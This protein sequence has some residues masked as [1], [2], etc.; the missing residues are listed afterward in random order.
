MTAAS[1]EDRSASVDNDRSVP[2]E[3]TRSAQ[4]LS[5]LF[6]I[7]LAGGVV[8][9][10]VVTFGGASIDA[11]EPGFLQETQ[12]DLPD[13]VALPVLNDATE[14]WGLGDRLPS[15]SI[16]P[17]AGGLAVG[18]LDGDGDLDLVVAHGTVDIYLRDEHRFAPALSISDGAM[19]VTIFDVDDD[20]WPDLLIARSRDTDLVIWGG[21]WS[22]NRVEPTDITP[23]EGSAPSA[24]LLAADLSGD[25]QV[26]IV[27]LGRGTERGAPDIIWIADPTRPRTFRSE[28]LGTDSRLSLAGELADIDH[29]GLVDLWV[30]RD[31]GWDTGA[32][33]LYSRLGNPTGPWVDIAETFGSDLQVD[34]MGVTLADL[35]DDR[36]LDAYISDLGD[37]EVLYGH[38][39]QFAPANNTGAARIRPPGATDDI[40]SSSWASGATDI[41]L[42]G[43][44]DLVVVNGGFA[45]GGMRNKI[46]DT[47]IA[48]E[49]P[50]AVLLGIGGGRFV[51]VWT[52]LGLQAS[53]SARGLTIADLDDDGDDDFVFIEADGTLRA[54]QNNTTG[55]TVTVTADQ[56][57]DPTGAIVS[58]KTDDSVYTTL[59]RPHTFGG[60][61]A[62]AVTI[63]LLRDQPAEIIVIWVN[64]TTT[65]LDAPGI[66]PR[67][68]LSAGCGQQD[69]G[70][71]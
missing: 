39:H 17:M 70:N 41:N 23:L 30:T 7:V 48:V 27:R 10:A 51:D 22:S 68:T 26:D 53:G 45:S 25:G 63:G 34:A 19:A 54:I 37:N 49:D 18:D 11:A 20:N 57:C 38:H 29:D 40:I 28:P 50:P 12:W 64:G 6:L 14:H 24:A 42:D 35:N 66:G 2:P 16:D 36:V 4:V 69:S 15:T 62:S 65:T 61:H 8:G 71:E 5:W 9:F 31:I 44:L 33:S 13:D 58:A 60:N 1:P 47:E 32:D 56:N 67:R 52:E 21:P 55:N 43:R 46:P 59:L 3:R